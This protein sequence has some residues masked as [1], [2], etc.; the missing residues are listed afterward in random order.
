[1]PFHFDTSSGDGAASGISGDGASAPIATPG[2]LVIT[3]YV[4]A[5]EV[6]PGPPL[7][8]VLSRVSAGFPSPAD[9][10]VEGHLDL[11]ELTGALSPSCY[12][13]RADGESMTG[14]GILSGDLLLVDR[15][16]E[17]ASGDVVVAAVDGE[18]TVKRFLRQ[19]KRTALLAAN[20]A[21]PSIELREGQDLVVW[22]VVTYVLHDARRGR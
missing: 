22:G 1:M 7:P 6:G 15:A 17:P 20:P 4:P 2:E 16:V 9:D 13:M 5:S 18:L 8:L 21:Y 3:A 11:H 14:A 10:Y 12:W 19:G